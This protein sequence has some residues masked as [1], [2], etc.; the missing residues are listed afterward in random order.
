[1]TPLTP[2]SLKQNNYMTTSSDSKNK[3]H[4]AVSLEVTPPI[5]PNNIGS[6]KRHMLVYKENLDDSLTEAGAIGVPIAH[7]ENEI[8]YFA[9]TFDGFVIPGNGFDIANVDKLSAPALKRIYFE[10]LLTKEMIKRGKPVFAICGGEQLVG[11]LF[12]AKIINDIAQDIPNSAIN[13]HPEGNYKDAAHPILIMQD[14]Y[15]QRINHNKLQASVNS[16]HHQGINY[17]EQLPSML[18]V[19]A[20]SPD[21]IVESFTVKDR[22]GN[23]IIFANQFHPE[24]HRGVGATKNEETPDAFSE[25]SLNIFKEFVESAKQS[26]RLR[27][28]GLYSPQNTQ[29]IIDAI[30]KENLAETLRTTTPKPFCSDSVMPDPAKKPK[31][32][33]AE[34]YATNDNKHLSFAEKIIDE[35]LNKTQ[36]EVQNALG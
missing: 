31:K 6:G 19:A 8:S 11:R 12:G 23:D 30:D 29:H 7:D 36:K 17:D 4:I 24:I 35:R 33:F 25:I 16:I 15:L 21:G 1:M 27:N 13:H 20:I 3:P 18:K 2:S 28:E 34:K 10:T 32:G 26:K 14:S 22:N 5:Q 9:D